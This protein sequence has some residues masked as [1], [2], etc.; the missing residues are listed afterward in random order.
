[1]EDVIFKLAGQLG[2][3][4]V[5]FYLFYRLIDKYAGQAVEVLKEINTSSI[6]QSEAISR[7]AEN[8]TESRNEMKD[9]GLALRTISAQLNEV[10]GRVKD[11]EGKL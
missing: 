4:I 5:C 2:A 7:I 11:V 1:M 10:L 3:P 6:R 8:M 9:V